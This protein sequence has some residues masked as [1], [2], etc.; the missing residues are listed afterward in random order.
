[1]VFMGI[2][3]PSYGMGR[4][5]CSVCGQPIEKTYMPMKEWPVSGPLCG[6]CYSSKLDEHYP[7]KHVRLGGTI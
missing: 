6:T 4:E 7:G 3:M 5:K 2:L 1:M